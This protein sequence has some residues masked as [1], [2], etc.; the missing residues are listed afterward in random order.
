[1]R[2]RFTAESEAKALL[3]R[4]I[5]ELRE[6]SSYRELTASLSTVRSY[7]GGRIETG[8]PEAEHV[9]VE[10]SSGVIYEV[11]TLITWDDRQHTNVRVIVNVAELHPR[12][13]CCCSDSFILAPDGSFIGE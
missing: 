7:L 8:G 5:D 4:R 10:S 11:E 6:E 2:E 9:E 1:M 12:D 13:V 3:A